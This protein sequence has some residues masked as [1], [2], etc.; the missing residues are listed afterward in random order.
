MQS[1]RI[2]GPGDAVALD[3]ALA[4]AVAYE[5]RRVTVSLNEREARALKHAGE[6]ALDVMDG[7][8]SAPVPSALLAAVGRLGGSIAW[9]EFDRA[10]GEGRR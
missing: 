3:R 1:R 7:M 4:R 8:Q 2:D 10:L 6:L 9:L 5:Q